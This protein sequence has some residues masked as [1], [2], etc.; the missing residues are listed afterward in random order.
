MRRRPVRGMKQEKRR[1]RSRRIMLTAV[2]TAVVFLVFVLTMVIVTG[3]VYG[4]VRAGV[5]IPSF[6]TAP[7]LL[8]AVLGFA[9]ASI[10]V[11]TVISVVLGHI[12]LKPL[13]RL[14]DGM[15]RLAAGDYKARV[16]FGESRIGKSLADSFNIL[17][18][19]LQNTEMLRSDFTNNFSHEFKTPI[20]SIYGFAKLLRQG[21]L[22]KEQEAEYLQI[23]E[24]ESRRLSM[25]ATNVLN[26]T[27]IENQK[28][29]TNVSVFNL[30]EQIRLCVLLLEK[31][32]NAKELDLSLNFNEYRISA[33]EEMLRQV[34]INLLDNAIKF[35]PQGGCISVTIHEIA[36]AV[37]VTVKNTG[38]EIAEKDRK[39]I[40]HKF[41]QADTSHAAEGTGTGLAIVQKI[42]ELHRGKVSVECQG[43]ETSF[44]VE[45]PKGDLEM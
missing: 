33:N 23:I 13:N 20:V 21:N 2:F 4:L 29:L 7:R 15:N 11:G 41:Y 37:L 10:V 19:E 26:L 6:H 43:G 18:E 36:D 35:S 5:L 40:F 30:S 27:K 3:A 28:I 9:A 22:P 45:L 16:Y 1:K 38:P 42:V 8:L 31:K 12:P 32:W 24:E 17:A 39:R 25:M 34:W 44:L 14:I